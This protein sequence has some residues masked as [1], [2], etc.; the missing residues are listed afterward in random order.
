MATYSEERKAAMAEGR[1]QQQYQRLLLEGGD[2]G[3]V[4]AG[5]R[6]RCPQ[7]KEWKTLGEDMRMVRRK[8]KSG[9][10]RWYA[11]SWCLK[12]DARRKSE[13]K[14]AILAGRVSGL[15]P[16]EWREQQRLV[17]LRANRRRRARLA[18]VRSARDGLGPAA[19]RLEPFP[20]LYWLAGGE[21]RVQ[22]AAGVWSE[23]V[24]RWDRLSDARGPGQAA[25][26]TIRTM[27][28]QHPSWVSALA[29][30]KA[31]RGVDGDSGAYVAE[32]LY[33]GA[34]WGWVDEVPV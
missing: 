5:D 9:L 11:Q 3:G 14:A 15:T 23:W 32:S 33:P 4:K 2:D 28:E 10:H 18:W 8:L 16:D 29:V 20:L 27:M 17:S 22:D 13:R 19:Q 25:K 21:E 24:T 6:H 26:Q 30:L 31:C 7:C 34:W 12:C 1:R